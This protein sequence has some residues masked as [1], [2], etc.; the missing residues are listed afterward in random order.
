MIF[1]VIFILWQIKK[2]MSPTLNTKSFLRQSKW[3]QM[4]N[5]NF[6]IIYKALTSS[7]INNKFRKSSIFK[8]FI[9]IVNQRNMNAKNNY[10]TYPNCLRW[11]QTCN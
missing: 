10:Y 5:V 9:N 6:K 3:K 1:F 8:H 11:Y 4:Y 2:I 7:A